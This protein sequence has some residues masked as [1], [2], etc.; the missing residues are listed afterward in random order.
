VQELYSYLSHVKR[1]WTNIVPKY[2]WKHVDE[3]TVSKLELLAP[4]ISSRDRQRAIDLMDCN[5]IF[6]T[7]ANVEARAEI[8]HNIL[9]QD[10]LIPSLR[11]FFEDQ[12]YLE[13]CS[14][15]LRSL[16]D[17]TERRPLWRAFKANYWP[18][19]ALEVQYADSIACLSE[20]RVDAVADKS[21]GMKLGYVQLWLFCMR[22]FPA[23]TD[24]K[25]RIES[26]KKRMVTKERNAARL[27]ELGWL[28]VKLGFKTTKAL[29]LATKIADWTDDTAIS[30]TKLTKSSHYNFTFT[31]NAHLAKRRRSGRPYDL[32]HDKD[33]TSLFAFMFYQR[34]DLGEDITPLYVKRCMFEAFLGPFIPSVSR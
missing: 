25:P 17:D 6:S 26:R 2:Y 19:G 20:L 13:P 33:L 18:P 16:L 22:H 32:D 11:T 24:T 10:R 28:A 30:M 3:E 5:T 14:H 8:L 31:S 12:K 9:G 34:I 27:H 23:M 4:A 21:L 15:V 7:L 29:S 1:I